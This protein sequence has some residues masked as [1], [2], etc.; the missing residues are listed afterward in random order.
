MYKNQVPDG[1]EDC[2][3]A[4]CCIKKNIEGS[5]RKEFILSGYEELETPAYEYYDIFQS[6]VGSYMQESMIKFVDSKGRI[7]VLR[8]DITVPAAR[9]AAT[10][11]NKGIKRLFYI[12]DSFAAAVPSIGKAGEFTQ[13]GIELI[14]DGRFQADAEVISLAIKSL[15]TAGLNEFTIDIGQVSFFKELIKGLE[16]TEEQID[17]LRHAVD[18]KDSM[19]IDGIVNEYAI[20]SP[21]KEQIKALPYLFGGQ[22]VFDKA[23]KL[24]GNTGC[25]K[26]VENLRSVYELLAALGY[27]DFISI[28][29][30]I[31]HDIAY[32]SGIIFRGITPGIGFPVLSG[33]RYDGL[34]KK[35]GSNEPATG[36]ALGIKRV[37]IAM[38]RQGNLSGGYDTYAAVSC[39]MESC[40]TASEYVSTLK[41]EGKRIV[42]S[43]GLSKNELMEMKT[44]SRAAHAFYFDADGSMESI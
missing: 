12:Q 11:L 39:D 21:L 1:V 16:L 9:V 22:E 32:Y 33:G 2:L 42:F 17:R 28:D 24:S 31:L 3:P 5:L 27:E 40:R 26:A 44:Y 29:F 30:G 37:M 38:E 8:P 15:K 6:G 4:E 34:L 23:L 43:F 7:I 20:Q 10:K 35:F 13:A 41:R 18:S 14:G 36:F 19:A 25:R